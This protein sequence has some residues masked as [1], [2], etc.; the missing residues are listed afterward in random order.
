[1]FTLRSGGKKHSNGGRRRDKIAHILTSEE[2]EEGGGE[3][4][5]AVAAAASVSREGERESGKRIEAKKGFLPRKKGKEGLGRRRRRRRKRRRR[6]RQTVARRPSVEGQNAAERRLSF[7]SILQSAHIVKQRVR[8][9]C[10][11]QQCLFPGASDQIRWIVVVLC[12]RDKVGFNANTKSIE[13][14]TPIVAK[15]GNCDTQGDC[16][17]CSSLMDENSGL[18]KQIFS[19]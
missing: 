8:K 11:R 19:F 7:F 2:G 18:M 15:N 10:R 13:N 14:P 9:E 3:G 5:A 16:T 1:M 17:K 12:A 6:D 4:G